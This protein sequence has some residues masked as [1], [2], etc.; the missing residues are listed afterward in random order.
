VTDKT[1]KTEK[2]SSSVTVI[3]PSDAK[4]IVDQVANEMTGTKR[5]FRTPE[6][7]KGRE[8]QYNFR[9]EIVRDGKKEAQTQVVIF[10]AGEPIKIDFTDMDI[11]R[12]VSK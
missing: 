1:E 9:A 3:V 11:V 8:F 7:P 5:E 4:L 12:T 10:K 6:L 2:V